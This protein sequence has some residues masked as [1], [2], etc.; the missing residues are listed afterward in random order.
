MLR[1]QSMKKFA[2]I[3]AAMM[4]V[5][6]VSACSG[7][8]QLQGRFNSINFEEYEDTF[9]AMFGYEWELLSIE[10]IDGWEWTHT[11]WT[12]EYRDGNNEIRHL[13]LDNRFTVC[14]NVLN[15]LRDIS[16]Y[17][18]EHFFDVYMSGANISPMHPSDFSGFIVRSHDKCACDES[19]DWSRATRGY[20]RGLNTPE[21]AIRLF[22]LTP[23]NI[24]ELAPFS[25]SIHIVFDE[26]SDPEQQA[27]EESVIV[28]IENMIEAMNHFSNNRLNARVSLGHCRWSPAQV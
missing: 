22:Q 18:R 13:V 11:E 1:A 23:A 12:I 7:A 17:Y 3:L 26:H 10:E 21:S 5:L 2:L 6:F 27:L 14:T 20:I 16:D 9:N 28:R 24:F 19:A 25:L 4:I 8:R 15:Y